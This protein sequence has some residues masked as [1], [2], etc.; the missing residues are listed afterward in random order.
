MKIEWKHVYVENAWHV[1]CHSASSLHFSLAPRWNGQMD[2][3][4]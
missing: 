2:R 3:C 4:H 1:L